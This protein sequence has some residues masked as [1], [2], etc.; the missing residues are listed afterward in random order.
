MSAT[1]IPVSASSAAPSGVSLSDRDRLSLS[2]HARRVSRQSWAD[3]QSTHALVDQANAMWRGVHVEVDGIRE[4]AARQGREQ[5]HAEALAGMA[6]QLLQAQQSARDLID[7]QDARVIDLAAALVARILPQLDGA[8]VIRPL[9]VEA[10]RSQQN[11]RQLSVY[12]HPSMAGV[13]RAQVDAWRSSLAS[14]PAVLVI[15][16]AQLDVLGLVVDGEQGSLRAGVAD[17]LQALTQ[18]LHRSLE[19][20]RS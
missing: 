8:A 18:S 2:V 19:E 9:L 13:V 4:A 15:E 14:A 3:L 12:V 10:L 6:Q 1:S 5:G 7:A 20:S 17:Q 16:D 11:E